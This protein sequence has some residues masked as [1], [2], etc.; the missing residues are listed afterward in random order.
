MKLTIVLIF[1]LT[2]QNVKGHSLE[3]FQTSNKCQINVNNANLVPGFR[4]N[5]FSASL[6][7]NF[8]RND[9]LISSCSGTLLNTNR[10]DWASQFYV[11]LSKHCFHQVAENPN[12]PIDVDFNQN[13]Q[14]VFH[15]QSPTGNT[16]DTR[17]PSNRGSSR[18]QSTSDVNDGYQYC[19]ETRIEVVS[20]G[21][22]GDFTLIRLITPVPPHFRPYFAG[23]TPNAIGL[24]IPSLSAIP[25]VRPI[26]IPPPPFMLIHHPGGDIKKASQTSLVLNSSIPIGSGCYTITKVI[27]FLFGWVWGRRISTQVICNYVD[28][29]WLTIPNWQYGGAQNGSSGSGL[30]SAGNR[31]FGI[32]SA[33]EDNCNPDLFTNSINTVTKFR[34][35]Y[36][37]AA[38]KNALNPW[39]SSGTAGIDIWGMSGRE[40]TCYSNLENLSGFYFPANHVQQENAVVLRSASNA[41]L[42]GDG[43]LLRVITGADYTIQAA[44][45]IIT[46]PNGRLETR[47]NVRF[48]LNPGTPCNSS[49]CIAEE[50]N[51]S[52]YSYL[53]K[54]QLPEKLVFS[55][56]KYSSNVIA[57]KSKFNIYPNSGA[58]ELNLAIEY[59]TDSNLEI[60]VYDVNGRLCISK[61]ISCSEILKIN[62]SSLKTGIYRVTCLYEGKHYQK[63]WIKE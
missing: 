42:V 50:D 10:E 11:L 37:N 2:V 5:L 44:G 9:G 53:F 55:P 41:S 36:Y 57:N 35:N 12:S 15:Y 8:I 26:I 1:V 38:V 60:K 17:N 24:S 29:P 31:L 27:D 54:I 34:N 47:P 33:G 39:Q 4:Y 43:L 48:I 28:N 13:Q 6:L 40:Q 52:Q 20:W 63:N 45:S 46:N 16:E 32:L 18:I 23:W 59:Q 19:H 3:S 51:Y 61:N 7:I 25:Q 49:G 30:F 22:W 62:T 56:E 14:I 58:N 21:F